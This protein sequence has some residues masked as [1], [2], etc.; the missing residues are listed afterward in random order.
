MLPE[1]PHVI[2]PGRPTRILKSTDVFKQTGGSF[3]S[4][5]GVSLLR[6]AGPSQSALLVNDQ[7]EYE[8]LAVH[9]VTTIQGRDVLRKLRKSLITVGVRLEPDCSSV[10][11]G[12]KDGVA[13]GIRVDGNDAGADARIK[14]KIL[15]LFDTESVTKDLNRAFMVMSDVHD[16]WRN[17]KTGESAQHNRIDTR[18]P[19]IVVT[20]KRN[21]R[22][23]R[24]VAP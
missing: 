19:H 14:Q 6:N 16:V 20:N 23:R 8:D 3:A 13:D 9:L 18:L 1:R 10:P 4:R 5:V 15:P 24:Q 17:R 22:R 12:D 7:R 21:K 11:P 2:P